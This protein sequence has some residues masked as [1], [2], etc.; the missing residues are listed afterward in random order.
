MSRNEYQKKR[1]VFSDESII[2]DLSILCIKKEPDHSF[3]GNDHTGGFLFSVLV[4]A[5]GKTFI[6]NA[7]LH[8]R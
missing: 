7:V 4:D 8:P 3:Y 5:A 2:S 1:A 6:S